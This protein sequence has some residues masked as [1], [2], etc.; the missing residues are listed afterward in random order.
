MVKDF[1]I[2]CY[3]GKWNDNLVY[4]IIG[5]VVYPI[6]TPMFFAWQL[7]KRRNRL[8]DRHVLNRLGFLYAIYRKET[9]LWDIWEM[10]QK[11]ILTGLIGLIFPGKDLQVVVVVLFDLFFLCILLSYKP[12]IMGPIR[13]LASLSSV[14]ITLTMYCGLVLKTVEGIDEEVEYKLSIDIFLISIN[15]AVAIYAAKQIAPLTALIK[16][17]KA[18]K[19]KKKVEKDHRAQLRRQRSLRSLSDADKTDVILRNL[20]VVAPKFPETHDGK[21]ARQRSF[22]D[23]DKANVILRN[24]QPLERAQI[25]DAGYKESTKFD[26]G[27]SM[28][29]VSSLKSSMHI[30]RKKIKIRIKMPPVIE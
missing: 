1:T 3:N 8:E 9:Y 10:I 27:L 19:E 25:K 12:H 13:V 4:G 26:S 16:Y 17:F 23:A 21:G 15:V 2:E 14:A 18:R 5:V 28:S 7:W 24:L 11:L 20:T 29:N 6:G 30:K 22:S